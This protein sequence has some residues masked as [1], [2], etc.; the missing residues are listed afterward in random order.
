MALIQAAT[1]DVVLLDLVMPDLGGDE[2]VRRL[3]ADP[4]FKDVPA[5]L[6]TGQ[7]LGEHAFVAESLTI[8]RQSGLSVAELVRCLRPSLEALR[9]P[10]FDNNSA[11]P[12]TPLA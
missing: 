6:L 12:L 1:P 11:R 5:V 3:R 2:L 7:G 9:G 4:S 8:S 10:P